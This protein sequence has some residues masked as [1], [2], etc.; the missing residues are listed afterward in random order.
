MCNG[1]IARAGGHA[2]LQ[3]P[4]TKTNIAKFIPSDHK[5][6]I[7]DRFNELE[8]VMTFLYYHFLSALHRVQHLNFYFIKFTV[9]SINILF[10]IY[11]YKAA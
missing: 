1:N 9:I 5:I 3:V 8:P 2:G 6:T 11:K 10:F 4:T 7:Q